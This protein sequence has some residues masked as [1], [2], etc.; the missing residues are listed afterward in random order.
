[1]SGCPARGNNSGATNIDERKNAMADGLTWTAVSVT[2]LPV[3]IGYCYCCCRA[4][5]SQTWIRALLSARY[6]CDFNIA[7]LVR[8]SQIGKDLFCSHQS[9][10]S[11][12]KNL[13]ILFR[14]IL[15]VTSNILQTKTLIITFLINKA[16]TLD[17]FQCSSEDEWKCMDSELVENILMPRNCSHIY[18][19][20]YCI[21]S[22][23]R[24]GGSY[25]MFLSLYTHDCLLNHF[26]HKLFSCKQ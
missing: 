22:I 21:K 4:L 19:A 8:R 16:V 23:G 18:E 3:S 11:I 5:G 10:L 6:L 26:M 25:F 24:Y 12:C 7:K 14:D 15:Y 1:M 17:C 20:R 2:A 9:I 13:H